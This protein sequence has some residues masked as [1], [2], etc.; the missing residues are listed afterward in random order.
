[1]STDLQ[2]ICFHSVD[3]PQ[4][5]NSSA[6]VQNLI[7]GFRAWV[8]HSDQTKET[9]ILR[10]QFWPSGPTFCRLTLCNFMTFPCPAASSLSSMKKEIK[11]LVRIGVYVLLTQGSSIDSWASFR[12]RSR[13]T[14]C[15]ECDLHCFHSTPDYVKKVWHYCHVGKI[16]SSNR[17]STRS[18][19]HKIHIFVIMNGC[20]I[21]ED[22][23]KWIAWSPMLLLTTGSIQYGML[24]KCQAKV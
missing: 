11:S 12:S 6:K 21:S 14:C 9:S 19:F 22:K 4:F 7:D 1:M 18:H 20:Y 3:F 16:L 5:S 24:T 10:N 15:L 13:Y 17:F 23:Q 2:L 8:S